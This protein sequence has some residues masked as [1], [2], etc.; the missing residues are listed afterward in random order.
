MRSEANA[1]LLEAVPRAL[2]HYQRVEKRK[3]SSGL[4]QNS[5]NQTGHIASEELS[6]NGDHRGEDSHTGANN[7]GS[8]GDSDR[9]GSCVDVHDVSPRKERSRGAVG[10]FTVGGMD[11]TCYSG[12]ADSG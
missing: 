11:K 4:P 3:E 6:W 8:S 9:E 10:P 12:N 5:A 2:G 7:T 1:P